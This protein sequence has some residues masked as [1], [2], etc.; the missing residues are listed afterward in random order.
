MSTNH[1]DVDINVVLRIPVC[2]RRS[3]DSL[4]DKGLHASHGE[5][6]TNDPE[7]RGND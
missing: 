3:G 4:F 5:K 1:C 2:S 6:Q 7:L